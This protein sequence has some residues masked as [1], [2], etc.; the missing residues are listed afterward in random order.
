MERQEGFPQLSVRI[1][2]VS[3]VNLEKTQMT[4]QQRYDLVNIFAWKNSDLILFLLLEETEDLQEAS[5]S[6]ATRIS[7]AGGEGDP[8]EAD[9]FYSG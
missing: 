1:L 5:W 8:C 2:Q 6:A 9:L 4:A 7:V 3:R